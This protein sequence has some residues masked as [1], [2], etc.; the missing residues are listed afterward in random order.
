MKRIKMLVASVVIATLCS[1]TAF[2]AFGGSSIIIGNKVYDVQYI[3]K[4]VR[5]LNDIINNSTQ[6]QNIYY[7]D[8]TETVKN[9]FDGTSLGKTELDKVFKDMSMVYYG[10]DGTKSVYQYNNTTGKF[11]K[12]DSSS[13]V[14]A[15]ITLSSVGNGMY[16]VSI[17]IK[18]TADVNVKPYTLDPKYFKVYNNNNSD[19]IKKIGQANKS[20]G[21]SDDDYVLNLMTNDSNIRLQ[22]LSSDKVPIA[23]TEPKS[24]NSMSQGTNTI[25]FGLDN[26]FTPPT[27][28]TST[29]TGSNGLGNLNNDGLTSQSG[30]WTYYSNSGDG[31][32]IYKTNGVQS[33]KICE[34][35]AKFINVVGDWI[36]YSNYSDGQKIYK[37]RTDGTG[38]RIVCTDQAS[39]IAVSGEFIY[40]SYHSGTG[41]GNIR[42]VNR[43]ALKSPGA[44]VTNDEA[45]F[46]TVSGDMIYF[47]NKAQG[48]SIYAVHTDGTYR[49][50]ISGDSAK[51][52]TLVNDKIYYVT[53]FGQLKWVNK[54]GG[55]F[56]PI[57]V[58][59]GN[60]GSNAI[61]TAMNI[62]DDGKWM[63]YADASDGNKM[64][65]AP[66]VD[67]LK[68]SGDKYSD[69]YINFIN[70]IGN[71][72]YYTKGG[73]MSIAN[74]PKISPNKDPLGR[75]IYIYTSTPMAK[76]KQ[77]LKLLS[78][79][80]VATPTKNA[81]G[82]DISNLEE[83]LPDKITGVLSDNSV[84]ELL[85]DWDLNPKSPGKGSKMQYTGTVVGYGAKVTLTL[86]M[87]SEPIPVAS[88]KVVNNAGL[89]D[90][91]IYINRD[92]KG[93]PM[94][95]TATLQVGDVI[96]VYRDPMK[97]ELLGQ[98]TIIPPVSGELLSTTITLRREKTITD[99][100]KFVY[101]TRTSPGVLES[102]VVKVP[103]SGSPTGAP[104]LSLVPDT[105]LKLTNY[106]MLPNG[107]TEN[108]ILEIYPT[109][110]LQQGDIIN[111]YKYVDGVKVKVGS[112]MVEFV[113]SSDPFAE[114]KFKVTM[115]LPAGYIEYSTTIKDTEH[116]NNIYI[117]KS[118]QFAE[119]NT[120]TVPVKPGIALP[121]GQVIVSGTTGNVLVR[122]LPMLSDPAY[123]Y[124]Y[125]LG[126][127]V[128]DLQAPITAGTDPASGWVGINADMKVN[129]TDGQDVYI[130]QTYNGKALKCG[131]TKAQVVTPTP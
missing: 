50:Q 130:L 55:S 131:N 47:T 26:F 71:K 106:G 63:Y 70:L 109:T 119:S 38:R 57:A 85:V 52:I 92:D 114:K 49:T 96:K 14:K 127:P 117:S 78:Y 19:L 83:Y 60:T 121:L 88:V 40:Y 82:A 112:Q 16:F 35:N 66:L 128:P 15:D 111:V 81:V 56:N 120:I 107:Y 30:D 32:G 28:G 75:A 129:V 65:R 17:R 123:K 69:D 68:I 46:L 77:N 72:V 39:Y 105:D 84:H 89:L 9:L 23:T 122:N 31:G 36:Y 27:T 100:A 108:D 118:T 2:A 45:E 124:Y 126:G 41:V 3:A 99:D 61:M 33:Y 37:V 103:I 21:E 8:S 1:T 25:E 95:P 110:Q 34:D 44:N 13:K 73:A 29:S 59:N 115:S 62:S 11:T 7:I 12:D 20:T 54:N 101:I 24:Y 53:D 4:N 104:T 6:Y 102:E 91:K 74:E 42:K 93:V 5:Q 87:A 43:N 51:F 18:S 58:T 79:D 97:G 90:D 22:I 116:D 80:K 86:S 125:K 64:Y 113:P 98:E 10:F 48:N 94:N 67:Y 76:P